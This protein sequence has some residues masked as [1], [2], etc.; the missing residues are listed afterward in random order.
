MR[1]AIANGQCLGLVH[2]G[3]ADKADGQAILADASRQLLAGLQA[4]GMGRQALA[5]R[6]E[7]QCPEGIEGAGAFIAR[8]EMDRAAACA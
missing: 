6:V 7:D 1:V 2:V 3:Q 5:L 4:F 8:V